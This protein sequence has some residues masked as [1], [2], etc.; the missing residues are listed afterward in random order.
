MR[1]R[2]G[3]TYT[4]IS[5]KQ[6]EEE[7]YVEGKC[8]SFLEY[9][10]TAMTSGIQYINGCHI[11][12]M[13]IDV[14]TFGVDVLFYVLERNLTAYTSYNHL[15]ESCTNFINSNQIWNKINE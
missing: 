7:V 1:I 8:L 4:V 12:I 5:N 14:S 2:I 10:M 3:K 9:R 13:D 6:W 11:Q 15:Q